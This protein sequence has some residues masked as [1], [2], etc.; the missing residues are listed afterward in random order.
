MIKIS[1]HSS[2]K[3]LSLRLVPLEWLNNF[4]GEVWILPSKVS[5]GS[6]L[7]EPM[8]TP[9]KVQVNGDHPRPKVK[10]LLHKL[11]NLLVW[12]LSSSKL[13]KA[14]EHQWH[15]KL[16]QCTCVQVHLLQYSLLLPCNIG[17]TSINLSRVL[18]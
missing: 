15:K 7:E 3:S 4:P 5:I 2:N 10:I 11:K 8:A 9:L 14:Q 17:T 6:C 16:E 13:T 1:S 18:S 12:N